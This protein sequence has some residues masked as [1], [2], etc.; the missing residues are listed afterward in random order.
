M[1]SRSGR[2]REFSRNAR[3]SLSYRDALDRVGKTRETD[4]LGEMLRRADLTG[5][6][7][8]SKA[9][10]VQ[11]YEIESEQLIGDYLRS[12]SEERRRWDRFS[13]VA[14][15]YNEYERQTQLVGTLDPRRP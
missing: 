13:S 3:V 1:A 2:R 8:L 15:E 10:P 12:R 14:E 7:I 5:D 6:E 9:M 4:E 11:A